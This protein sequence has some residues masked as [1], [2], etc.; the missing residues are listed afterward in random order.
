MPAIETWRLSLP[1]GI[2]LACRSAG[3]RGRPV[4]V[5][6]HGFPEAAF[7]WDK[8]L[9]HFSQP[10][11]GGYFCVAPNLRGYE[12]SSAPLELSAYHP[13]QLVQDISALARTLSQ[14]PLAALVAH[15]WGGA[16]AWN[17]AAQEPQLLQRLVILNA[18]HPATFARELA[19][20]P[21]Q[22]AASAYMNFLARPDAAQR[23]AEDDFRRL[24]ALFEGMGASQGQRAWLDE[25]RRE[26][27]RR[28]WR[29]GLHGPCA[30]YAATALKP[31]A[32][33]AAHQ[34]PRRA[35]QLGRVGLPTLLIWGMRDTALLPG[36]LDGLQCWVPTLE[37]HRIEDA[38]HWIV[39]EQPERVTGLIASFL[40]RIHCGAQR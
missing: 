13:R 1:N 12:G 31:A 14:E 33:T 29:A 24:W 26:Q 15:D 6:L 23:L 16:L 2:E 39:H 9:L 27:Y 11:H 35:A 30:Y 5:F 25:P 32:G 21:E 17:L 22:Q 3:Q 4:M 36:L 20:S 34:T 18:P 7:V 28:A 38:T 8:L 37:L 40:K 19:D 10:D